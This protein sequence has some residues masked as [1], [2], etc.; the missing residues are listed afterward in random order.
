MSEREFKRREIVL[1]RELASRLQRKFPL[2][3]IYANKCP[4]RSPRIRKIWYEVFHE[5]CPPLQPEMDIIILEPPDTSGA[6]IAEKLRAIEI[7]LYR[8]TDTRVSQSFYKGI[9]QSLALLRWGFDNVGLWQL[10]EESFTDDELR[11]YGCRT[12]FYIHGLLQLP[13]EF[14]PIKLI[15][16]RIEHM[17]FQ[18][19]QADWRNNL[20]PIRLRDIDDPTFQFSYTHDNPFVHFHVPTSQLAN[21]P[22]LHDFI[23]Q[24]GTLRQFLLE[25]L[26]NR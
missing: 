25:W 21:Y 2:F 7:K 12:W 17:R 11:N 24:A 16:D 1:T 8:K 14:T 20:S 4:S 10:F 5:L 26:R 15:G 9:E 23:R 6:G 19:I 22:L 13:I 18:V 3:R